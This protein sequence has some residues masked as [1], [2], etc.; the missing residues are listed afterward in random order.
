MGLTTPPSSPSTAPPPYSPKRSRVSQKANVETSRKLIRKE[1]PRDEVFVGSKGL[2]NNNVP[3]KIKLADRVSTQA[4]PTHSLQQQPP[5]SKHLGQAIEALGNIKENTKGKEVEA[6]KT[7]LSSHVQTTDDLCALCRHVP[8]ELFTRIK[9][10]VFEH[11]RTLEAQYHTENMLNMCKG[12]KGRMDKAL[13]A[14]SFCQHREF[15]AQSSANMYFTDGVN[16]IKN[17]LNLPDQT[18]PIEILSRIRGCEAQDFKL[19]AGEVF[20]CGAGPLLQKAERE[21]GEALKRARTRASDMVEKYL[22]E[23]SPGKVGNMQFMKHASRDISRKMEKSLLSQLGPES[24]T[25]LKTNM[26]AMRAR[27]CVEDWSRKAK[28]AAQLL[29]RIDKMQSDHLGKGVS[30]AQA[31]SALV[32]EKALKAD[33]MILTQVSGQSRLPSDKALSIAKREMMVAV[34]K[35]LAVQLVEK[36]NKMDGSDPEALRGVRS[37]IGTLKSYAKELQKGS[38]MS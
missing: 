12:K 29:A 25:S 13:V 30:A 19:T 11:L 21:G 33:A 36:G 14:K 15:I 1:P 2:V 38:K 8:D 3:A 35:E 10:S 17:R 32:G 20:D 9:G 22:E 24:R 28:T 31:I 6:A 7:I 37:F 23:Q 5:L 27:T 16:Y 4:A 18:G 26:A 34:A